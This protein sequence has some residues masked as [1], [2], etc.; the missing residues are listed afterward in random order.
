[1]SSFSLPKNQIFRN[2]VVQIFPERPL[3]EEVNMLE[4]ISVHRKKKVWDYNYDD[5]SDTED[6]APLRTS[7]TG[8][9]MHGLTGRLLR[10]FRPSSASSQAS[11]PEDP[12]DEESE[13]PDKET[14]PLPQPPAAQGPSPGQREDPRERAEGLPHNRSPKDDGSNSTGGSGDKITFN[15]DLNSVFLRALHDDAEDSEEDALVLPPLEEDPQ[16]TESS[17]LV[18]HGKKLQVLFPSLPPGCL[19][20]GDDL[21]DE[22]DATSSGADDDVRDG[23]IM[24]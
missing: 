22:S 3:S 7:A 6:E 10:Q 1:M 17:L 4:V 16:E 11:Y 24:R 13:E 23:Y 15:V 14:E 12:A 8:Y 5:E 9:T 20:T 19:W 21:S 18:P 2:F